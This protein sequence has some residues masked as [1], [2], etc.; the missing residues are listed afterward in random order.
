VYE[1]YEG[2][3]IGFDFVVCLAELTPSQ[4]LNKRKVHKKSEG[5]GGRGGG[6]LGPW[7]QRSLG[8]NLYYPVVAA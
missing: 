3:E 6:R 5:K 4:A 2:F 7:Q 1:L 8:R